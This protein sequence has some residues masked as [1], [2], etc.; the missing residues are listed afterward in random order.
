MVSEIM[1]QQTQVSR[2]LEKYAEWMKRFPTPEVLAA[3]SLQEVLLVWKGLGYPRRAKYLYQIAQMVACGEV[4]LGNNVTPEYL[5]T[6]PGIGP[7]TARAIYTFTQNKR[8]VFIE[9]NIRTIFTHH[10]FSDKESVTDAELL[11]YIE[12][13]LPENKYK[14]W[15]WAL[16]DYGSHL[17]QSGVRINSRST[18]Y[19]KQTPFKGSMR[20]VRS[21]VLH[22][23]TI[24]KN[25]KVTQDFFKLPFSRQQIENALASLVSDG[26]IQIKRRRYTIC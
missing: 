18:H 22:S 8:E 5:D 2:V 10:F 6:L 12:K 1:L 25:G 24:S 16:M 3:A 19:R 7:Y 23:L 9:T 14:E 21:A 13:S 4:S 17:K 11:L 20:E 15:Y 26:L